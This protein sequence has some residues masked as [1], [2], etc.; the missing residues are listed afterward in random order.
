MV[1]VNE[2][3]DQFGTDNVGS[4]TVSIIE[5]V[6]PSGGG[7]G[8]PLGSNGPPG[9]APPAGGPPPRAGPPP[10]GPRKTW[11]VTNVPAG[12]GAEGFDVS[13]DGKEICAANAQD[14]TLTILD[15]AN[16]PVPQTR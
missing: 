6:S 11:R 2:A 9:S 3:L 5:Q 15:L 10:G 8:P 13:P 12:H 1:A 16:K 14:P 7:F 4:R